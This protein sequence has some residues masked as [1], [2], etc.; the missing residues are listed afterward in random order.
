MSASLPDAELVAAARGGDASCLGVL[1]ERH[2]AAMRAVA[3]RLLGHGPAADDA[4]QDAVLVALCRLN[5]LRDPAAVGAWLRT[6]VRN[7]CRMQLRAARPTEPLDDDVPDLHTVEEELDRRALRDWVWHGVA[8]LSEPLQVVVLLRHFGAQ[9]SYRDI[10][11]IC[12]VPVG[13]VRS[14]LNEARRRIAGSLAAE[15]KAAHDDVGALARRRRHAFDAMLRASLRGDHAA[16]VADLARPDMVLSGWWGDVPHGRDLLVRILDMDAAAGVREDIVDVC[17]TAQLTVMECR[18]VSPPEDP[19]HCPPGVLWL[20][21]M[22]GE[23]IAGVRLC[24]PA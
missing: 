8:Q 4:V 6:V 14:R 19:T 5:E 10:A 16:L 1:I 15:A 9:R 22:R 7:V 2:R 12:G 23:R 17:G 13:T 24:H 3:V 11:R 18:L 20:V 21:R